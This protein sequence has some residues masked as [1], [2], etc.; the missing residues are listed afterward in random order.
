MLLISFEWGVKWLVSGSGWLPVLKSFGATEANG[1]SVFLAE[2]AFA[3]KISSRTGEQSALLI[4]V[5]A[6]VIVDVQKCIY[7]A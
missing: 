3:F 7:R 1:Q 6:P 4:V 5:F 2:V